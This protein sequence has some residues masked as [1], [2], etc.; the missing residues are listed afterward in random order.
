MKKIAT[1]T[2]ATLAVMLTPMLVFGADKDAEVTLTGEPVDI[3][4]FMQGRSGEGH[5]SCAK[6][7]AG[8]GLPIGLFVKDGDKEELYL[9]LGD[10]AKKEF[11]ENMGKQ[12]KATGKVSKKGGMKVLTLSKVEA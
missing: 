1:L 11:I 6:S 10:D 5:A 3:Q 12:I 8:K 9:V 7:C 4:C 2:L